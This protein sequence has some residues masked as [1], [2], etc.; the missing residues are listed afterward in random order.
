MTNRAQV[1]RDIYPSSRIEKLT[2]ADDELAALFL[3]DRQFETGLPELDI[4]H[5]KLMMLINALGKM[6]EA[7]TGTESLVKSLFGVFDTLSDYVDYHFKFEEEMAER[8]RCDKEHGDVHKQA[9]AEFIREI[10]DAREAA[11]DHPAEVVARTINSLSKWLMTHIVV[12]D[13]RMAK[14]ILAIQSGSS[15]EEATRQANIFMGNATETLLHTLN[16]LH[17]NLT[18]RTQELVKDRSR[19]DNTVK[20]RKLSESDLRKFSHAVDHSPLSVIITNANSRFVYV[21]PRFTQLTGF[22]LA[23]LAGKTPR[24][25]RS[26]VNSAVLYENMWATITAG[27]DWHGEL[28]NRKKNGEMFWDYAAISPVFDAEGRITHYVSIQENITE[29]KLADEMLCQQSHFSSR[30]INSL[31]GIFYMQDEQDR[32]IQVNARF[33][34]VT[35]YSKEQLDRMTAPDIFEL[36]DKI[37]LRQKMRD[38]F[39]NGDLKTEAELFIKSGQGIPYYLTLH[40][41]HIDGQSY[42]VGHGTDIAARRTLERE[43]AR[44]ARTESLVKIFGQLSVTTFDADSRTLA[45]F[46]RF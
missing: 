12:T 28:C 37:P 32:L 13:M 1:G 25:L 31:P 2:E 17:E 33:L 29:R 20:I 14:K 4:Q 21:N 40:R 9:H 26:G 42:L 24:V 8:Y 30:V 3:W 15:E 5:L 34:E 38:V 7:D 27:Q 16:R 11:N 46:P 35:G 45:M 10:N 6:L 23:E 36:G 22:S 39:K 19:A 43:L 44:Q 41:T 18:R